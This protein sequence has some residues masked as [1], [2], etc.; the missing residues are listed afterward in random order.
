MDDVQDLEI[1]LQK[2]SQQW[3]SM[4]LENTSQ[5]KESSEFYRQEVFPHIKKMFTIKERSKNTSPVYGVIISVGTSPEPLVLSI[6]T[7]KPER[8]LFLCSLDSERFLDII[9][10]Q[11][12]LSPCQWEK[13]EIDP[14]NPL[15]IYKEIREAWIRWG[16]RPEII[17]DFTGG[18]KSM[19]AGMA[20]AGHII[21]AR[22]VYVANKKYLSEHR[23]PE[24]GTEYLEFLSNP[25]EIFGDLEEGKANLLFKRHDFAGAGRIITEL[26]TKVAEPRRYEVLEWYIGSCEAWD[27]LNFEETSRKLDQV[28]RLVRQ[29]SI[30]GEPF[31]LKCELE[32]LARQS[33]YLKRLSSR[34]PKGSKKPDLKLLQDDISI[35]TLIFTVYK[36]AIRREEQGKFD[37]AA[38]LLY[39]LL[40]MMEQHRL[41]IYGFDTS[42]PDYSLLPKTG[43]DTLLE[44]FNQKL[45]SMNQKPVTELPAQVSLL[46]GYFFLEI[47]VDPFQINQATIHW[48]KFCNELESRNYSILTHGFALVSREQYTKFKEMVVT[49]LNLFCQVE[50]IDQQAAEIEYSFVNPW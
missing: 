14:N 21:G 49:L 4:P 20:M 24:P 44:H 33:E 42:N 18:T 7:L 28:I 2:L 25:Y 45:L 41:A 35:K 27:A 32:I 19:S 17:V 11:T 43:Q 3:Q 30:S 50:K 38:L 47:I 1:Q 36:N 22:M 16:K 6:C 26:K 5:Q 29:Y 46:Q 10:T 34:I 40:E 48:K 31:I 37:M 23:R 13:R 8:V 12:K 15:S 9:V 39:R